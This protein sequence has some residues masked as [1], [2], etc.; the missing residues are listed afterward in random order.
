MWN[1]TI[2]HKPQNIVSGFKDSGLWLPSLVKM[3]KHWTLFHDG[4]V[5]TKRINSEP[6][7]CT[8]EEVQIEILSLPPPVDDTPKSRKT[9]DVNNCMLRQKEP[10]K[11]ND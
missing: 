1:E 8:C 6:W 11:Y 10:H 2:V 3:K 5:K 4:G 9:L 7:I